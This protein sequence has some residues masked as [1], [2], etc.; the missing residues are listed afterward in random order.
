MTTS[1]RLDIVMEARKWLGVR[2]RHQGRSRSWGVDCVGLIYVVGS[3]LDLMHYD[4]RGYDRDSSAE[5]IAKHFDLAGFREKDIPLPGDVLL[6]R[7]H[8]T[9]CHV[10]IY[11]GG[12][13]AIHAHACARRVV[14]RK[15]TNPNGVVGCYAYPGIDDG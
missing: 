4:Y 6:L 12:L 11:S 10:A 1:P 8:I 9:P 3:A 13:S 15:Y 14:E 5:D 2:F 7:D